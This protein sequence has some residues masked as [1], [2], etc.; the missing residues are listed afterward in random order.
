MRVMPA[1]APFKSITLQAPAP[2]PALVVLGA[3]HG[4]ETCGTRAIER[5]LGE[6]DRGARVLAA[7]RVTFVPITNALAHAEQRRAGDRNLNRRLA[8]TDTPRDFEDRVANWLCP[9]LGAHDVLLDL[10][11]F[12]SPGEPFA[13]LG[14]HDNDGP[15]EPFAQAA[16]EE[17]LVRALGVGR[18]VDGWLATYAIGVARRVELAAR[19]P[20]AALDLDPRY[21]IGTT[22]Y[23]RGQGGAAVTLECG[24]HDDPAA[25]GVAYRAIVATLRHLGMVDA[26]DGVGD[27][28]VSPAA[29]PQGLSLCDVVDRLHPDDAFGR[30]WR[31]FDRLRAGDVVGTRADGSAV[32][33]P[34]DGCIVFPN[35]AA[36]P[37]HEWFYLARANDRFAAPP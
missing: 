29:A 25:P 26:G 16:R 11:S 4:N 37:G 8:P 3:V 6:F 17:G 21:G 27:P 24:Q 22:E 14:P 9:I 23:M 35:P 33:A 2:G 32:T 5:L 10:H 19:F 30:A 18:A 7:G 13:L 15:L 12:K 36:E 20:H 28:A 34:F 1:L 31:S